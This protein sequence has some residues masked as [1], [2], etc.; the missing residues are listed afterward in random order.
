MQADLFP[1]VQL[2]QKL[3]VTGAAILAAVSLARFLKELVMA[4]RQTAKDA[5]EIVDNL[6]KKAAESLSSFADVRDSLKEL[7]A[8]QRRQ[9]DTLNLHTNLL[10][11]VRTQ[12][13]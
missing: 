10:N 2:I 5:R 9:G 3:G 13:A 8:E 1:A 4:D 12:R 6:A 11:E 7:I